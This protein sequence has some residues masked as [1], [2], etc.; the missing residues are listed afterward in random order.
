MK[1]WV[2][3]PDFDYEGYGKPEFVFS[4]REL[5]DAKLHDLLKTSSCPFEIFEFEVDAA[6]NNGE[7]AE[8]G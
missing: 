4:S 6:E 3:V 8:P 7:V 1:V 2:L 5:A